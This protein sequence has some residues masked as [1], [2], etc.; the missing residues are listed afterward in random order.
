LDSGIAVQRQNL[1]LTGK[2]RPFVFYFGIA[3][4]MGSLNSPP[5][6]ASHD[7]KGEFD[8]DKLVEFW[9]R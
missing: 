8:V 7:P 3:V 4:S 2:L 6:E 9:F 1:I 5:I